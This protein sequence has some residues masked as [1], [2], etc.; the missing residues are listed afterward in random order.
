MSLRQRIPLFRLRRQFRYRFGRPGPEIAPSGL[1]CRSPASAAGAQAPIW[2]T[3]QFGARSLEDRRPR[4]E[5]LRFAPANDYLRARCRESGSMGAVSAAIRLSSGECRLRKTYML[6]KDIKNFLVYS[7]GEPV[8]RIMS[9]HP[10]ERFFLGWLSRQYATFAEYSPRNVYFEFGISTG[11]SLV[12]F[13][14]AAK[15]YCRRFKLPLTDITIYAFDSFVGLP[16]KEVESDQHVDWHEGQFAGSRELV[17]SR[18]KQTGFPMSNV[19]LIDGFYEKSLTPELLNDLKGRKIFP[20]IV[21]VDVDYYSSTK[22]VIDWLLPLLQSGC[23]FHFDDIWSFHGNP[24]MGQLKYINEFN[25]GSE[26][27]F[28]PNSMFGLDSHAFI[29]SKKEWEWK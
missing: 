8:T 10:H 14:N 28:T 2:Q 9:P 4:P 16:K 12:R 6:K 26:G 21:N 3:T 20:S 5:K 22:T 17:E 24:N 13:I 7:I 11:N 19:H 1:N 18:I 29:Y 27:R 23:V 15:I 25:S